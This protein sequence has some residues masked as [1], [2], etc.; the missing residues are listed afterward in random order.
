VECLKKEGD[1]V[2]RGEPVLRIH[3]RI[4]VDAPALFARIVSVA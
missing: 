3:S 2:D 4:P 1:A